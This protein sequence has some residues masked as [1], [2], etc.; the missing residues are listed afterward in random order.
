VPGTTTS[1]PS[2]S[3]SSEE[4]I[5][6][7]CSEEAPWYVVPAD[8]KWFR[9][10]VVMEIVLHTLESMNPRYPEHPRLETR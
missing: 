9:N 8:H 1:S 2:S 3:S 7:T 4:A 5:A 10:W 6:R